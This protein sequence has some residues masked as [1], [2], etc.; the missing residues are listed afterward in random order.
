MYSHGFVMFQVTRISYSEIKQVN[1]SLR[2]NPH[3]QHEARSS[4][5]PK[6]T[7]DLGMQE[8]L[9]ATMMQLIMITKDIHSFVSYHSASDFLCQAQSWR[10]LNTPA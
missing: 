5:I 1:L 3:W 7:H 2:S 10:N 6:P 8:S 9:A 4:P